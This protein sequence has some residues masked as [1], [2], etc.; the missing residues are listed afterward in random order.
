MLPV[1]SLAFFAFSPLLWA[2]TLYLQKGEEL[3]GR[4]LGLEDGY[5]KFEMD[6]SIRRI[7]E[8]EVSDLFMENTKN[9][10]PPA[11]GEEKKA[12]QIGTE[13]IPTDEGESTE[14][15]SPQQEE[16]G[17]TGF[18]MRF[19][20]A[21][22]VGS[23]NYNTDKLLSSASWSDLGS[24]D[25]MG[26]AEIEYPASHSGI[27]LRL[28]LE[29]GY[30]LR[31]NISL[32][33]G[34][35]YT[36]ASKTKNDKPLKLSG[37]YTIK[38]AAGNFTSETEYSYKYAYP[39]VLAGISF[40]LH[41]PGLHISPYLRMPLSASFTR[42]LTQR[43]EISSS[44]GGMRTVTAAEPEE[45][46]EKGSIKGSKP[47]FGLVL[48]KEWPLQGGKKIGINLLYSI[49]HLKLEP[50]RE[51]DNMSTSTEEETPVLKHSSIF[52]GIGLHISF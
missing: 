50:E 6:G 45:S 44:P 1:L 19:L 49:D 13:G 46:E 25:I 8:E 52:Y 33:L 48:G 40:Y 15:S 17:G 9:F 4:F 41:S 26:D 20:L 39:S 38:G 5:Y 31:P 51:E 47:G 18:F 34:F 14:S 43:S 42:T 23:L 22:G 10:E 29:G 21:P 12:P 28:S 37:P 24:S 27:A 2:D 7:P 36:S 3:Q 32:Q 16:K 35:D 11:E 30:F